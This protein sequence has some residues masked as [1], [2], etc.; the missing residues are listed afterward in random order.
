MAQNRIVTFADVDPA[1]VTFDMMRTKMLRAMRQNG[2]TSLGITSPSVG[3]RQDHADAST[4][5]SA[6]PTSPTCARC[7][8]TSTCAGRRSPGSSG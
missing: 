2:W 5:P 4:W 1:H 7:S 8:S 3:L 6:S